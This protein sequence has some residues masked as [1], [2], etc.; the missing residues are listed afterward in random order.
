MI[1]DVTLSQMF[2]AQMLTGLAEKV[3][4]VRQGDESGGEQSELRKPWI[5]SRLW[6]LLHSGNVFQCPKGGLVTAEGNLLSI[7]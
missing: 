3:N 5:I 7:L 4:Q 2:L 6:P 1:L